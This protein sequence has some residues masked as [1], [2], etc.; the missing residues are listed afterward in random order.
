MTILQ[1]ISILFSLTAIA[2]VAWQWRVTKKTDQALKDARRRLDEAQ[3][4]NRR[5][6]R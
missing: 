1:A 2:L 4:R 6:T 5:T 3:E